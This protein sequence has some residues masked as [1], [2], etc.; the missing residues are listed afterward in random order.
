MQGIPGR[1]KSSPDQIN[2]RLG[3]EFIAAFNAFMEH[4]DGKKVDFIRD[5]LRFWMYLHQQYPDAAVKSNRAGILLGIIQERLDEVQK[6]CD[7]L[8][9]LLQK[10]VPGNYTELAAAMNILGTRLYSAD[11]KRVRTWQNRS[12]K[13]DRN[14]IS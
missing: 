11:G 7:E 6:S 12:G 8:S 14:R 1:K 4:H 13:N 2:V 9:D 10:P 5:A 3:S